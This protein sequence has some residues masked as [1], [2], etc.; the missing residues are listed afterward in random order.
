VSYFER[1]DEA[2][3]AVAQAV[4]PGDLLLVKGSRGT[5]TDLV[6]DRLASELG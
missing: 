2:A 5:R 1:S 6:V 3:A 4:Q